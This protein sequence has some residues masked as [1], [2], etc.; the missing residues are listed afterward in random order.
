MHLHETAISKKCLYTQEKS[1][2][3]NVTRLVLPLNMV[4]SSALLMLYKRILIETY[5]ISI[6]IQNKDVRMH[7]SRA[8]CKVSRG[9]NNRSLLATAD[10]RSAKFSSAP[11]SSPRLLQDLAR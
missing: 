8:S 11:L 1:N 2:E 10:L 5:I 4:A 7:T 3:T 6:D 9:E